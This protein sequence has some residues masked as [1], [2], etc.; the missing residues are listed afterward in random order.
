M[1]PRRW[2]SA[3]HPRDVRR[4]ASNDVEEGLRQPL[5]QLQLLQPRRGDALRFRHPHEQCPEEE[6][7]G[8]VAH[9]VID[10]IQG[11]HAVAV[12]CFTGR[13]SGRVRRAAPQTREVEQEVHK[14]LQ[15]HMRHL[16][17]RCILLACIHRPVFVII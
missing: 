11:V 13:D 8:L 1:F 12:V 5:H 4:L 6:E 9:P 2:R 16:S 17:E 3:R 14:L 15:T 7:E 10:L